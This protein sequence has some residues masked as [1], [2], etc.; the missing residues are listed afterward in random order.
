MILYRNNS[1]G[2]GGSVGKKKKKFNWAKYE[3]GRDDEIRKLAE[4]LKAVIWK[5]GD[6]YKMKGVERGRPYYPPKGM[7]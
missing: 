7:A 4:L 1:I 2:I 6:P 5:L 3:N